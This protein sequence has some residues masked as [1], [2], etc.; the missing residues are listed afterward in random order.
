MTGTKKEV[1]EIAKAVETIGTG[2][3]GKQSK[4][5]YLENLAQVLGIRYPI[6]IR[7]KS[8]LIL[9][10]LNSKVNAIYP[11]FAQKLRLPIKPT[12]IKAQKING[13]ILNSFGMVVLVHHLFAYHIPTCY[14]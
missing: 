9:F 10:D 4:S 7:K 3:D 6:T 1:V 11:I 5:K 8:V 2:K 14:L 12:D 13:T